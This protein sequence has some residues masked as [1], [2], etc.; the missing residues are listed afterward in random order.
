MDDLEFKI[1]L[2]NKLMELAD[3]FLYKYNPCQIKDG[4]CTG[5]EAGN[6]C[7]G[8]RFRCKVAGKCMFLGQNG[9]TAENIIC[10]VW[11]C[12]QAKQ[13]SPACVEALEI[14][15]KLAKYVEKD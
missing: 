7:F 12:D 6:C 13:I 2:H 5:G 10:K 15:E 11:L 14:I 3:L 8:S 9:C 4:G 1:Q